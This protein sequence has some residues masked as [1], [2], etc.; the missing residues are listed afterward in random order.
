MI[1]PRLDSVVDGTTNFGGIVSDS[2][3]VT[4][5][6]VGSGTIV[7]TFGKLAATLNVRVVPRP[8]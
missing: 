4:Y 6:H 3:R 8:R 1:A 5:A 2:T 7:A